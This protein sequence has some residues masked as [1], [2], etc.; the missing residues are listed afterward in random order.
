MPL[1]EFMQTGKAILTV[2]LPYA[3]ETVGNYKN[4]AFVEASDS[5][6]LSELM[7]RAIVNNTFDN[8]VNVRK[9]LHDF[10]YADGWEKLFNIITKSNDKN[11]FK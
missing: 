9:N 8:K 11:K 5:V 3:H 2:D 10:I 6:K 7:K 4:V 1:T